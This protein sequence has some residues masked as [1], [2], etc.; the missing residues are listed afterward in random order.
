MSA[1][2]PPLLAMVF[3]FFLLY[4]IGGGTETS[5]DPTHQNRR[6]RSRLGSE[7]CISERSQKWL[8]AGGRAGRQAGRQG[9]PRAAWNR[10]GHTKCSSPKVCYQKRQSALSA[11]DRKQM[12]V[13][14][15]PFSHTCYTDLRTLLS[16]CCFCCCYGAR[17]RSTPTGVAHGTSLACAYRVGGN[18]AIA[19]GVDEM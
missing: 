16:C 2:A 5:R 19:A 12:Y 15:K 9:R 1:C 4:C 11:R 6:R 8:R 14:K 10:M 18:Q 17:V 13:A 7:K 3:S